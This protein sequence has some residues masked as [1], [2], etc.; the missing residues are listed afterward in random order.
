MRKLKG[1]FLSV[2]LISWNAPLYADRP[3][4]K[5]LRLVSD[6]TSVRVGRAFSVR[7]AS[8][9]DR[10]A[11]VAF[12]DDDDRRCFVSLSLV[13]AELSD[14]ICPSQHQQQ[15]HERKSNFQRRNSRR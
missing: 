5:P 9:E 4:A 15:Q 11:L 13:T 3:A 14:V 7:P 1:F 12:D 10:D 8:T 6:L 2:F